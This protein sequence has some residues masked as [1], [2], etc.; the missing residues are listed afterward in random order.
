MR[1]VENRGCEVGL[2]AGYGSHDSQEQVT[3]EK[4]R[5][6]NFV[7]DKEYGCRQH[8]LTWRAADTWRYQEKAGLFYDSSLSFADHIGFRGGICFPFKPFDLARSRELD[9]WELPLTVMEGSLQ[10]AN[11]QNLPPGEAYEEII[12]H[13]ETAK[14]FGGVF[15]LLWHNS[16]FDPLRG[17]AG[18][19]GV[20]EQ[21][22]KY[23]GGQDAFIATGREAVREWGKRLEAVK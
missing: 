8:G 20:Y 16:S 9:I 12:K 19:K 18:W 17:W 21:V 14:K 7:A 15:V 2:H 5:L 10:S 11:Y 23:I 1:Q 3:A 4:K 6:D 22:V 13:L